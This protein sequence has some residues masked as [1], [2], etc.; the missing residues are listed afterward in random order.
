MERCLIDTD[1]IIDHLRGEEKARD[2]LRQTKSEETDILYSV[3]TK[4]ELYSGV[5]QKEEEKV[6]YLLRSIE[7]VR[8]DGEIAIHAGRYR[9]KFYASHG[10]LL[11]DALIAASAKKVGATLV[12]LNKKHYPMQDIKI[13]VPYHK[14]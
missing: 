2:F 9:N 6:S 10:L 12:T 1:I 7:E 4:A 11:P 14:R 5:R 8:I 13:Q 3:I